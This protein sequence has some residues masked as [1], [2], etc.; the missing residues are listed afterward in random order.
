[1]HTQNCFKGLIRIQTNLF[2]NTACLKF[3]SSEHC[4]KVTVFKFLVVSLILVHIF[5]RRKDKACCPVFVFLRGIYN[6]IC[7]VVLHLLYKGLNI[8]LIYDS[9][10]PFLEGEL[11]QRR[12]HWSWAA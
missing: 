7:H 6:V 4:E 3:L 5:V 2:T 12:M 8:S 9:T 11:K 1:M 10:I